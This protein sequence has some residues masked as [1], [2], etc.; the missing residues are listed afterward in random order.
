MEH[1]N[2]SE[3]RPNPASSDDSARKA[4]VEKLIAR[5]MANE[6]TVRRALIMPSLARRTGGNVFVPYRLLSALDRYL[7]DP[8]PVSQQDAEI[9]GTLE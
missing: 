8:S 1:E 7:T 6:S 2:D 3:M 9:D 4:F 5:I